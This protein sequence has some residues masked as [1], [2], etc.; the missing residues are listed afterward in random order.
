MSAFLSIIA[1]DFKL[2]VRV[3]GDTLTVVLFFLGVGIIVPFAVG[4]DRPLLALLSPA[5]LWIAAFL[6]QLL[7]QDRLFRGDFE[8]GSLALMR[9]SG[10]PLW[11]VVLAKLVAHW[12]TT[13]AP[14]LLAT[15]FLALVTNMDGGALAR[16]LLSLLLGTPALVGLGAVGAAVTVGLKRGGLVAPVLILPLSIPVI[17]FGVGAVATGPMS[18][19]DQA[20]LFL[21]ALSLVT[22]A[23]APFAAALALTISGE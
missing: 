9:F 21:A 19:G 6:S 13:A 22:I 4:P 23:F 16:A 14:L 18:G 5:I 17:I 10:L 8:D 7:A 15:P 3:G 12:L 2:A 11:A 1:R 20:M